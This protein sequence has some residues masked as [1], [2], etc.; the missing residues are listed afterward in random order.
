MTDYLVSITN[1]KLKHTTRYWIEVQSQEDHTTPHP[2]PHPF[3]LDLC[4]REETRIRPNQT[5]GATK[6][7]MK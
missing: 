1:W 4:L 3:P 7:K 6:H 2:H 5:I